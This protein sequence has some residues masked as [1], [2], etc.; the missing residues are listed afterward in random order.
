MDQSATE[1][2]FDAQVFV[3]YGHIDDDSWLD[4]KKKNGDGFVSR[5][6][7]EL[8]FALG[9]RGFGEAFWRDRENFKASDRIPEIIIERLAKSNIFL[10]IVSN[11][12][13]QSTYCQDEF[14][15]FTSKL[16]PEAREQ[17]RIFRV[18]KHEVANDLLPD[19]L[20][21]VFSIPFYAKDRET[22]QVVEFY[23]NGKLDKRSYWKIAVQKL[24]NDIFVR[25][26]ELSPIRPRPAGESRL[27]LATPPMQGETAPEK[28]FRTVY[29]AKPA[30][31][32]EDAY[33]TLVRELQGRNIAVVPHPSQNIPN[34]GDAA[35]AFVH[36]ALAKA[37]MSIHL[38]GER[39]GWRP[40][41]L[42][43][44]IVPLQLVE[45]RE[46]GA[47]NKGF[48]RLI[49]APKIV[50]GSPKGAPERDGVD[51]LA[52]LDTSML[53]DEIFDDT[54]ARFKDFLLQQLLRPS[55]QEVPKTPDA[56]RLPPR[57]ISIF[58]VASMVDRQYAVQ[59]AMAVKGYGAKPRGAL[60]SAG[61]KGAET[62][63]HIIICWGASEEAE[64]LDALEGAARQFREAGNFNGKLC[65]LVYGPPSDAKQFAVEVEGYGGADLVIDASSAIQRQSL[66]LLLGTEGQ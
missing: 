8:D 34:D 1:K 33:Q 21:D 56:P 39:S 55:R 51:V 27:T 60:L 30:F 9:Q 58:V 3:S 37:D 38:V 6:V 42:S 40:D 22:G 7:K 48:R 32:L 41:G 61:F 59:A 29:M 63:N 31:D 16:T 35:V 25:L 47:S 20:K 5:L 12:Y 46:A 36:E 13:V 52:Q 57:E 11:N 45:A 23:W 18:D 24:A 14:R 10:A 43:R 4:D 26:N 53:N 44:G 19:D 2:K 65:L 62:C 50:P 15:V 54:A 49:W 17:K 66:A 64:V 28:P